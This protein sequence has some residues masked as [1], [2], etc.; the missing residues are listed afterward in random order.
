M[1][2]QYILHES[3]GLLFKTKI[4]SLQSLIDRQNSKFESQ[5]LKI[6]HSHLLGD[7]SYSDQMKTED[8][9]AQRIH[10]KKSLYSGMECN[11]P[12]LFYYNATN[13]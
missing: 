8:T 4:S 5:N 12:I 7:K 9:T 2:C 13:Y 10:A 3:Q 1:K 11:F 6:L